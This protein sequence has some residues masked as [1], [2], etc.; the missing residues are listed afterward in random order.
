MDLDVSSIVHGRQMHS[1]NHNLIC[2]KY[3][4]RR[5]KCRSDFPKKIVAIECTCY[6]EAGGLLVLRKI[7]I[8]YLYCVVLS[9]SKVVEFSFVLTFL[10]PDH[11]SASCRLEPQVHPSIRGNNL[12]LRSSFAIAHSTACLVSET[13]LRETIFVTAQVG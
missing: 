10:I 9:P 5:K 13:C 6:E 11:A 4:G 2:F 1:E 12:L 3:S 8:V 7:Q